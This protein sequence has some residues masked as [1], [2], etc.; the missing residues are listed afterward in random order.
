MPRWLLLAAGQ[1]VHTADIV[2]DRR[3]TFWASVAVDLKNAGALW[4]DKPVVRDA[5]L[6]T[7]RKPSDLPEFNKAI[8]EAIG[9]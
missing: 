7:S 9:G 1:R 6:I 3:L 5:S 8:I 4:V 2:R